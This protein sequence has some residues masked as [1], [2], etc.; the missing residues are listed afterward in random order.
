MFI[1]FQGLNSVTESIES[2]W[3]WLVRNIVLWIVFYS[4][5]QEKKRKKEQIK[6]ID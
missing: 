3:Y 2:K 6:E 1:N 5:I 4:Y